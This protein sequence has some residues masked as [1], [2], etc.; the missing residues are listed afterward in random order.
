MRRC[1]PMP[2]L[3]AV[4]TNRRDLV[5]RLMQG[6]CSHQ[7]P[8]LSQQ[9]MLAATRLS[10]EVMLRCHRMATRR[11]RRGR[12]ITAEVCWMVSLSLPAADL[13]HRAEP[14]QA[15]P[16]LSDTSNITFLHSEPRVSPGKPSRCKP[17]FCH[18]HGMLGSIL[19]ACWPWP[20]LPRQRTCDADYVV[21]ELLFRPTYVDRRRTQ[22]QC[23]IELPGRHS[24]LPAG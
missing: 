6:H 21:F 18:L 7:F 22:Y 8:I 10:T 14:A 15:T 20:R 2:L 1:G 17:Y 3:H 4:R 16:G 23:A 9:R 11:R 5:A 19:G 13:P 24:W 12:Q